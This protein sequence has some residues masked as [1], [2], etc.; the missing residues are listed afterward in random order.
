MFA[1]RVSYFALPARTQQRFVDPLATRS[2]VC[3][4]LLAAQWSQLGPIHLRCSTYRKAQLIIA[5]NNGLDQA[6]SAR[7]S[8]QV[9]SSAR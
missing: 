1:R 3:A 4:L 9:S 6:L 5:A 2:A 8:G 7:A